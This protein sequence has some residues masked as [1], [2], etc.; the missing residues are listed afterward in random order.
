MGLH[1]VGPWLA[2]A[3]HKILAIL[4]DEWWREPSLDEVVQPLGGPVMRA[5]RI[6][7][8][9]GFIDT[10]PFAGRY[11]DSD[12]PG[13]EAFGD[14]YL[15]HDAQRILARAAGTNV[16]QINGGLYQLGYRGP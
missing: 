15:A 14:L 12:E 3:P 16:L 10:V 4:R 7:I 9:D 2:F 6:L 8:K 1:G 11:K 13:I 5:L